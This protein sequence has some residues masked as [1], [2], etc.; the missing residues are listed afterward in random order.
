MTTSTNDPNQ[1][2][3]AR[4]SQVRISAWH[5]LRRAVGKAF[6]A[7]CC[8]CVRLLDLLSWKIL[9]ASLLL[10]NRYPFD[11]LARY[12][13]MKVLLC[14]TALLLAVV[15]VVL[16]STTTA[17]AAATAN[18]Q[19]PVSSLLYDLE[20]DENQRL[21]G[22]Y[23]V[24]EPSPTCAAAG[25]ETTFAH[26]RYQ[27]RPATGNALLE[28]FS[29]NNN[30]DDDASTCRAVCL[31]RG[32]DRE[33]VSA[34]MPHMRYAGPATGFDDFFR[35]S[36]SQVESCLMNY[37]DQEEP[38]Q[39]YWIHPVSGEK[40]AHIKIH[41]GEQKTKCF[42]TFLGHEFV[43]ETAQGQ[44]IGRVTI[45]FITVMA[46]GESPPCEDP[47]KHKNVEREIVSTLKSEW[48]RHERITRTFS[49]LG[50]DKGRLP[51]DVFGYLGAFYYNNRHNKVLEEWKGK[52]VFVN[53]WETN[54]M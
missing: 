40:K 22:Y 36:C 37:Y 50:F 52:G 7:I 25:L 13:A 10:I 17:A 47:N 30:D 9:F 16:S 27:A 20:Y 53:W 5:L 29:N 51:D 49:P 3:T 23:L 31:G 48:I 14:R 18:E 38:L 34:V 21:D 24:Y 33:L 12:T 2:T 28:L 46:F 39:I 44:E 54:G 26:N 11:C 42:S 35:T 15:V 45:E 41:Y 6:F 32:V 4:S 43:A 1:S 8:H 19:A